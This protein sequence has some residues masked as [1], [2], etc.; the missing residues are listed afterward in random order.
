M[1]KNVVSNSLN[2]VLL[3]QTPRYA[4]DLFNALQTASTFHS[5]RAGR[6]LP[7]V[8]AASA[9]DPLRR[10][11]D[12]MYPHLSDS[13]SVVFPV[14]LSPSS[15]IRTRWNVLP[16]TPSWRRQM[17]PRSRTIDYAHGQYTARLQRLSTRKQRHETI[18]DTIRCDTM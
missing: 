4:R 6:N 7:L 13:T 1:V 5:F 2:S 17:S 15:R 14:P 16:D 18:Y 3:D 8:W 10:N 11:S 9:V 12:R